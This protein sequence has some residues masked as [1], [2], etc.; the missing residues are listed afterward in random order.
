M[1]HPRP[2]IALTSG[3][4]AGIGPEL[5]AALHARTSVARL[6][7]LGDAGLIAARAPQGAGLSAPMVP[8]SASGDA[9]AGAIE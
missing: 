9:P 8:Y 7:V 6:V 3:E 1:T 4:P 5:C 2:C